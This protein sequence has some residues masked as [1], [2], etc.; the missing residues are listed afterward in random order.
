MTD[1]IL[2]LNAGSS[3]IKFSVFEPRGAELELVAGGQV[4]GLGTAPRF[5]AKD[6]TG[7]QIAE[8]RWPAGESV[9]HDGAFAEIAGW[10]RSQGRGNHRLAAVGHRVAHG[11]SAYVAPA[12]VDAAMLAKL[13][14]LIPI[15]P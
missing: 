1:A 12:R 10:L 11:A 3:S 6:A 9:S 2:V 4:E 7:S 8:K 14:T 13:E 15:A 5:I